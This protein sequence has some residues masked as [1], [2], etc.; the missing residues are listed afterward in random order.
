[1]RC[2]D[3]RTDLIADSSP[4][5]QHH[6]IVRPGLPRLSE[7]R[8]GTIHFDILRNWL[9][10][11]DKNHPDCKTKTVVAPNDATPTRLIDV[12]NES[13]V[14]LVNKQRF[15]RQGEVKYVAFSHPWGDK[16]IHKHV[17]TTRE[18]LDTYCKSG[19]RIKDLPNTFKDAVTITRRLGLQYLWIDSLC[20]L[21]G[22]NGDFAEESVRMANVFSCA[23]CVISASSA[24][25][26]NSQVL[27]ERR[28]LE[29]VK[30]QP[31]DTASR[32]PSQALYL[33]ESVNDFQ[34][35]VLDGPLSTR[36]WVLQERA[37]SRRTIYF[38]EN[39]TY[40]ECGAGI[41]CETLAKMYK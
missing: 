6:P 25:G 35:D 39:Q 10:D 12:S 20:I 14:V 8:T 3:P 13:I 21:Q 5:A 30:F 17:C 24:V 11:C 28:P 29:I 15:S 4:I 31:E 19:I 16:R 38:T 40:W 1:M 32:S 22:V 34:K 36:G 2:I 37:L 26:T 7:T 9:S 18:N 33:T 41:R 27:T 23:Y